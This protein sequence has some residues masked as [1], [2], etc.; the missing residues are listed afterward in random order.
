[1]LPRCIERIQEG[2][3][4]DPKK[5]E[6]MREKVIYPASYRGIIQEYEAAQLA[7]SKAI[8]TDSKSYIDGS[9]DR[10]VECELKLVELGLNPADFRYALNI[11]SWPT[12]TP[13]PKGSRIQF[14]SYDDEEGA[15]YE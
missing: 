8:E 11:L 10:I 12:D 4:P 14:W 7:Y 5:D 3:R 6:H 15:T 1:M 13:H 2:F 9:S